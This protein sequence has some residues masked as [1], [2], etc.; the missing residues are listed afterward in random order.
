MQAT[1]AGAWAERVRRPA[2]FAAVG[3]VNTVLDIGL[4]WGLTRHAHL[5]ALAAT[6][7]GYSAG[8]LHG[9]VANGKL[10]FREART[11]LIAPASIARFGF[12]T[13]ISLAAS[14]LTIS[15]LL[16]A[17]PDMPAK[18]LSVGITFVINFFLSRT[19]VYRRVV[20]VISPRTSNDMARPGD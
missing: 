4:F 11:R 18:V 20:K 8:S 12:V 19:V 13:G 16:L 3:L 1:A 5:H 10:T 17:L 15:V 14:S 9:Y 2:L 7:V 6:V